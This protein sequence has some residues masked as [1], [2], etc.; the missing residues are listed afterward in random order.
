MLM[1]TTASAPDALRLPAELTHRQATA[2]L[3]Q[4]LQSLKGVAPGAAV[5]VDAAP[6]RVFDTSALAVLLE[7]RREALALGQSFGVQGLPQSLRGMAGLYGV[8]GLLGD[9]V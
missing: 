5:V 3:A 2:C 9:P 4:L 8:D 1:P 6:L 7:F